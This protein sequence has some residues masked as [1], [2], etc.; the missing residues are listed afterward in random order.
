MGPHSSKFTRCI[1]LFRSSANLAHSI[2]AIHGLGTTSPKTWE[3]IKK[4]EAGK[5]EIC[6]WLSDDNML[7]A[8]IPSARIY[9]FNWNSSYYE[10][11]P[12]V[13]I[14]DVAEILLSKIIS[15]R[16]EVSIPGQ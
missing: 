10:D 1:A 11:A 8:A 13:R 6:N 3:A 2:I 16:N 4:N 5:E 12:I 7:P 15:M 14:L 9:T